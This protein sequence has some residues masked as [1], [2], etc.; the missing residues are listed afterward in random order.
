M[1]ISYTISKLLRVLAGAAISLV[2]CISCTGCSSRVDQADIADLDSQ[3]PAFRAVALHKVAH[4]NNTDYLARQIELLADE[5]PAVRF[6]AISSLKELTGTDNGYHYQHSSD[7]RRAA[8]R[9]WQLWLS[10]RERL[11]L[12]QQE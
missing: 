7:S 8:I 6:Y 12:Q 1:S 9:K 11:T 4:E 10:E 3:H 2:C 5:D